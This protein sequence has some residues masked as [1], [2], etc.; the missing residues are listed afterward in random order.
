M[1]AVHVCDICGSTLST[2]NSGGFRVQ[3]YK[4]FRTMTSRFRN[5]ETIELCSTCEW[6]IINACRDKEFA[7]TLKEKY[8]N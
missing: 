5:W 4:L 7:K 6:M 3:Q 8:K 1:A 2:H